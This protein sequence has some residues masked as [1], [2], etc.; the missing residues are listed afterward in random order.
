MEVDIK[1]VVLKKQNSSLFDW[2]MTWRKLICT[3]VLQRTLGTTMRVAIIHPL[4]SSVTGNV[5]IELSIL[6]NRASWLENAAMSRN[7]ARLSDAGGRYDCACRDLSHMFRVCLHEDA[8]VSI[9]LQS[10]EKLQQMVEEV[11]AAVEKERSLISDVDRRSRDCSS[12]ADAVAK[13]QP[14]HLP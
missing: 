4:A 11:A 10:P 3:M 9:V 8:E 1:L 12:R 6:F 7:H 5:F 14:E 2:P 13:V